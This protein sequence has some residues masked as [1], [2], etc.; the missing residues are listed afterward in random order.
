M[1]DNFNKINLVDLK[2]TITKASKKPI[3]I[4]LVGYQ[5]DKKQIEGIVK[6]KKINY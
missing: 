5:T 2:K 6:S 1:Y 4:T 3:N